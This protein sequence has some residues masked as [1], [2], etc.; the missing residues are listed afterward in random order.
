ME[1]SRLG[2]SLAREI[3]NPSLDLGED[4][5]EMS[6]DVLIDNPAVKEI[7]IV[8]TAMA[9][10]R[11]G[12]AIRDWHFTR[13][14]LTFLKEL[15]ASSGDEEK[16]RE[17]RE[18]LDSDPQFAEKVV[19]HLLVV[20]DRYVTSEKAQILAHLFTAHTNG[21]IGWE[22]F[23]S[24]TVVL[25]GLQTGSYKFLAQMADREVPFASHGNDESD[26]APL[27]AAGIASRFGTRFMVT[28]LGIMLYTHGIK[29]FL[30]SARDPTSRF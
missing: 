21:L 8:K 30:V 1:Q 27:Y 12:M 7:P 29:P 6:I 28:P 4:Y 15:H 18:R 9:V 3:A 24:S 25:D 23:V 14:L 13:K 10:F 26:Q 20:L 5:A 17:F 16:N 22:D 11:T 2:L 19:S